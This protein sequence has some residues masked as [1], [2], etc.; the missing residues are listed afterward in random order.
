MDRIL[1]TRK[2]KTR[3]TI[4]GIVVIAITAGMVIGFN[5]FEQVYRLIK[6]K[7]APVVQNRDEITAGL[8]NGG[9]IQL[10]VPYLQ[11]GGY[12]YGSDDTTNYVL[13]YSEIE[14][15]FILIVQQSSDENQIAFDDHRYVTLTSSTNTRINA[16][17]DRFISDVAESFDADHET[18]KSI[19]YPQV[20]Y[21][22]A[23]TPKLAEETY[24]GLGVIGF[25]IFLSIFIY[26]K[27]INDMKR[28]GTE[29]LEQL[30]QEIADPILEYKSHLI[31]Q[32]YLINL[33]TNKI[34][35]QFIKLDDICWMYLKHVKLSPNPTFIATSEMLVVHTQNHKKIEIQMLNSAIVDEAI[36]Q[37]VALRPQI[38]VGYHE[39][40]A[41]IWRKATDLVDLR[42]KLQLD[43]HE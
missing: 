42:N 29:T 25:G 31:T 4:F 37:I 35:K 23:F 28:L 40:I 10:N 2:K 20:L 7:N 9:A 33:T 38:V 24:I 16:V 15:A 34:I 26:L 27:S 13:S 14:D 3:L 19:V 18:A 22:E 32:N 39:D 17:L 6:F 30:S 5:G 1:K 12:S 8:E 11:Y 41:K 43:E 36:S 21:L